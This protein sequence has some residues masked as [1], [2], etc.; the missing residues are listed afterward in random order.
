M[1]TFMI[2]HAKYGSNYTI[3]Y[4]TIYG[5]YTGRCS[6]H[7][8]HPASARRPQVK[9]LG[10]NVFPAPSTSETWESAAPK[11]C[12]C[13]GVRFSIQICWNLL[14]YPAWHLLGTKEWYGCGH[15]VL[16][17]CFEAGFQPPVDKVSESRHVNFLM[18]YVYVYGI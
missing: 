16:M 7:K 2:L 14:V 18:V 5:H 15:A 8:F 1:S 13:V 17:C 10:E 6:L 3:L 9:V 12:W 4:H 11:V